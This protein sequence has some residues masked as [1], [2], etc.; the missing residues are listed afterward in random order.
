MP[1]ERCPWADSSPAMRD[2]HDLEWGVPSHD[3]RHL[4]EMLTL[5]GAQAGLSWATI[6]NRRGGY[7][8]AFAAF[9]AAQ[10]AAFDDRR[11]D[12]L[13][14]DEGII[15][16]RLKIYSTRTNA[17]AV[18]RLQAEFGSFATYLWNWV[19]GNR[20]VNH[21]RTLAD[22]SPTTELS[23]RISRDLKRHDFTFV[24]STI[25]YSLLE[26]VGIVDDHLAGCPFKRQ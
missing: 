1:L 18:I 10:V 15:R 3:D 2:Y 16:N 7:R 17:K 26:A 14:H 6:L 19:D 11:L 12:R 9:D 24:G 23:D 20:I 5:E 25:V 13:R 22:L 8:T 21:P 4:F